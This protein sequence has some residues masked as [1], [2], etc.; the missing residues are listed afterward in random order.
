MRLFVSICCVGLLVVSSAEAAPKKATKAPATTT[1]ALVVTPKVV[2]PANLDAAATIYAAYELEQMHM[3][4]VVDEIAKRFLAG[5]LPLSKGSAAKIYAYVDGKDDRLD[6]TARRRMYGHV[7]GADAPATVQANRDFDPLLARFV[8]AVGA[9]DR[10]RKIRDKGSAKAIDAA[11]VREA[12]RALALNLSNRTYGGPVQVA[13]SLAKLQ[14]LAHAVIDDAAVQK[15]FGVES[16]LDLVGKVAKDQ[17][18]QHVNAEHLR[19]N[20]EAGAALIRS[21]AKLSQPIGAQGGA[22]AEE[23]DEAE[24]RASAGRYA[25]SRAT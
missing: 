6:Q 17:L 5:K 3:F 8:E 16:S 25:S 19:A 21:L 4:E 1:A 23:L 10:Q 15:A 7:L 2:V 14:T 13:E 18:G 9:Y 22:P 12:A 24:R 11:A 20:A